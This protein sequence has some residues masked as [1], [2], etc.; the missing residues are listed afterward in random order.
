[1]VCLVVGIALPW[2]AVWLGVVRP[3]AEATGGVVQYRPELVKL[4]GGTFTMGSPAGEGDDDEHP[5]HEVTV[6]A[7]VV[8]RTEV[9]QAQWTAVMGTAPFDCDYGCGDDLPAHTVSWLDAVAFL[10][11]LS[12][13]EGLEPCYMEDGTAVTWPNGLACSGYRLPTEAEWE[14]AARGGT[15]TSYSFGDDA[16]ALGDYAWFVENSGN[17]AHAVATKAPN[18]WG[19]HDVHGNVWEWV[20]DSYVAEAYTRGT[21]RDPIVVSGHTPNRVLR[22]GSFRFDASW[23]RSANRVRREPSSRF[24]LDGFRCV[25]GSPSSL[26]P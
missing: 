16:A 25:R 20:W 11:A 1:V 23:L 22:G 2:V 19:L 6:S 24:P 5:A 15:R 14:F 4:P 9:T 17:K 7:F 12:A 10:N 13:L 26:I 3:V 21:S 18:P 8:C